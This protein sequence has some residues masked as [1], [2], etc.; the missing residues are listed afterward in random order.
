[1][2]SQ[3]MPQVRTESSIPRANVDPAAREAQ[4]PHVVIIGGG[5]AGLYAAME[6]GSAPVRVT[7]VDRANHHLFQPLL[8]QVATA[9]LNPSDIAQPIRWI[10]RK[11]KNTNVLLAEVRDID[12]ASRRVL[13]TD[14]E[15]PFD[16]LIVATGATH[17][18][19]G[20]DAWAAHAPGLKEI[21][22][23]LAIRHR[24]LLS[25]EA[26]ERETDAQSRR[27]IL[28]FVIVGGG[29]TGVELAGAMAEISRRA[30]PTEFR[31]IDTTTA[32][33]ILVQGNERVLPAYD[34]ALSRR[35][36]SDLESLGV[37]VWLESRVTAIDE[38]GVD[39]NGGSAA[40]GDRIAA[41]NVFWAAGVTASPL[42][43]ALG[44]PLDHEGR[45][46]VERDLSVP[47]HPNVFVTGDLASVADA[48]TG[49]P[50]PG[51]APAA[52]QMGRHAA[53]LIAREARA[54][55]R[56]EPAPARPEFRYHDRGM[57]A[58][59]GRAHA[60]GKVGPFKLVG[61]L[62]WLAWTFIH[63]LYLVGFR[64]RV[65]VILQWAWGYFSWSRGARLI[66]TRVT[67]QI[68]RERGVPPTEPIRAS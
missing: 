58:T 64:S 37:D 14:G 29:P 25:F 49:Q 28:T 18:Y 35:A 42:G 7:L 22:D 66:T 36:R 26:A 15:L 20:N 23:A 6:L 8:Y 17:S 63:I 41:R 19:F 56:H 33:V 24:F 55:R 54:A 57:L 62:A 3:I 21:G 46:R 53:R 2:E 52:M 47:G 30:M 44:A 12:M 9:A 45:V 39:I 67:D 32:R 43:R 51:V 48:R 10:L 50:V 16:V 60:V 27:A 1:M 40:G 4:P 38:Q 13:L 5:F 59:I 31:A 68:A 65:L 11:Q 34:P 61:M